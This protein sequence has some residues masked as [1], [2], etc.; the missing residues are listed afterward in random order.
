MKSVG[1]LIFW[2]FWLP[3]LGEQDQS[4]DLV[5]SPPTVASSALAHSTRLRRSDGRLPQQALDFVGLGLCLW[6]GEEDGDPDG[7]F[8][9][10]ATPPALFHEA[11]TSSW[12]SIVSL[13][14]P[15]VWSSCQ[16]IPLRC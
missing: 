9:T 4:S 7:P 5:Q 10:I 13:Q 1:I 11:D 12:L 14:T 16:R 15:A 8:L 6:E 3:C 2:S